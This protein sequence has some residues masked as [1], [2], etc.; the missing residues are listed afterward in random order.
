VLTHHRGGGVPAAKLARTG[1]T[2]IPPRRL[3]VYDPGAVWRAA[4]N[5]A[6]TDKIVDALNEKVERA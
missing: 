5:E 4:G 6:D 1:K 3:I 2:P